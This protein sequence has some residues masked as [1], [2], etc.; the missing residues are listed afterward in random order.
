MNNF[1]RTVIEI[2]KSFFSINHQTCGLFIGSCFTENIGKKLLENKFFI[3][4]NPF[5]ILY[6]PISILQCLKIL[7]KNQHFSDENLFF[8]NEEWHN[9]SFH[10][11]FSHFDKKK[12]LENINFSISKYSEF[13]KKTEILFLT[14][15]T[16]KVYIYKKTKQIVANCHKVSD[17][18]FERKFLSV[19]E[20]IDSYLTL[21]N[22]LFLQN[23]NLK[24]V[25]TLSPVRHLRDGATENQLSKS[26]L[27]V[28]IHS[29]ISQFPK[30]LFYFPAYEIMMDE[31]RDYRFYNEDF[32]HPNSL[33][34]NYIWNRFGETFFE[35]TT[36]PILQEME[37]LNKA[38]LHRPVNIFSQ[39]Y[40]KF[41]HSQ[42]HFI[43]NLEKK[44][45]FLNFEKE[46]Q[47]F[48]K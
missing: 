43:E 25:L 46:K 45:P 9:F 28:A 5:G 24:I 20:I 27:T 34:I 30:N 19:N 29:L 13:L 11:Q 6:N 21:F 10:G 18:E 17:K 7:M 12:C 42:Q 36:F 23:E 14:F 39:E 3:E 2:P 15:G 35:K 33:G 38:I 48:S 26:I 8:H 47:H 1:F 4:M 37:R 41:R 44:Y 16:A 22:E 40:E 32:I 31:L